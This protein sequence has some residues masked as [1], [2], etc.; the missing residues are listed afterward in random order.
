M[1]KI[2]DLLMQLNGMELSETARNKV[3]ELVTE[4]CEFSDYIRVNLPLHMVVELIDV[5]GAH[6]A[7][8]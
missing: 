3:A 6:Y 7:S 1:N 8:K 4:W 5:T 2:N